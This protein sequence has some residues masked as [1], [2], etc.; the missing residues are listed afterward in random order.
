VAMGG[1]PLRMFYREVCEELEGGGKTC[2][3]A[4][5]LSRTVVRG[6]DSLL[7]FLPAISTKDERSLSW[8]DHWVD[9][10]SAVL[11]SPFGEPNWS[12]LVVA[13]RSS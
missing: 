10:T 2:C 9:H 12:R 4:W 7:P 6:Q 11:R 3:W 8:T 5:Y 13:R 1:A